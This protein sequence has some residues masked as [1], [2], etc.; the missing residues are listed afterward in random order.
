MSF[1]IGP[2]FLGRVVT[3]SG[4]AEFQISYATKRED[5]KNQRTYVQE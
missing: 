1:R 5:T 3:L 2:C 4:F